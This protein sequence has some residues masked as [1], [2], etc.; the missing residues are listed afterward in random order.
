MKLEI[1]SWLQHTL[2]SYRH[3]D[4]W[5]KT[6]SRM[7]CFIFTCARV[8][9]KGKG[10][11]FHQTVLRELDI[12]TWRKTKLDSCTMYKTQ[13]KMDSRCKYK[14][15]KQPDFEKR[16]LGRLRGIGVGDGSVNITPKA[17]ATRAETDRQGYAEPKA[18]ESR[19][20]PTWNGNGE[21]R[22]KDCKPH[23][24]TGFVSKTHEE[25]LQLS[26]KTTDYPLELAQGSAQTILQRRHRPGWQVWETLPSIILPQRRAN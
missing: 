11:L 24:H 25:S 1:T 23:I 13:L 4:Q 15:A 5:D 7:V 3:E 10:Q 18:L 17:K 21:K 14:V 19:Q 12:H 6:K 26:R 9:H 22:E 2:K 16:T 20:A 8:Q